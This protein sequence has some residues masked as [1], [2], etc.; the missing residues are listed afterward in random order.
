MRK[1]GCHS[2][3]HKFPYFFTNEDILGVISKQLSEWLTP[4]NEGV[5]TNKVVEGEVGKTIVVVATKND[6]EKEAQ[7]DYTKEKAT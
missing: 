2:N 1:E 4:S 7:K 3:R 6:K 5:V